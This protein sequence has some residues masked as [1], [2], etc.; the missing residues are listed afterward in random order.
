MTIDEIVA[1]N[2]L[3]LFDKFNSQIFTDN[4]NPELRKFIADNR[5]RIECVKIGWDRYIEVLCYMT[6]AKKHADPSK[7]YEIERVYCSVAS[8]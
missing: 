6:E 7:H 3:E 8:M 5:E 4:T 1:D 2:S